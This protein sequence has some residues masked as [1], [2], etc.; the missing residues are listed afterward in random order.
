[1]RVL[2]RGG[3]PPH[4]PVS[5]EASLARW[6][7]GIFGSNVG[8]ALYLE[9]VYRAL[10]TPDTEMTV[11]SLY[12]E[13]SKDPAAMA[14]AINGSFDAYVIPLANAFRRDFL[15]S[16][17]R[18]TAVISLLTI[19][20]VITGV[21]GQSDVG[22][23][24]SDPEVDG[25]VARFVSAVLDRSRSLGVRGEQTA[26]YLRRLGFG[27]DVVDVIGCPSMFDHDGTHRVDRTKERID[28]DS[29]IAFNVAINIDPAAGFDRVIR[30]HVDAYPRLVYVPQEHHELAMLL[31][32]T[33]A[34]TT[35]PDMPLDRT[36][37]FY[38]QDRIRFFLDPT[39][40]KSFM[41]EQDF[42]FGSRIH[43]NVAALAA[44]TPA[45]LL[46]HDARTQELADYHRIP[47]RV[48]EGG[49]ADAA[50]LYD[51]ASFDELNAFMPEAFA[52][53]TDFLDRNALP[54]IHQP[55][56]ANPAYEA[57]LA[58][59][60]FPAAVRS[61]AAETTEF[62]RELLRKLAWLRQGEKNDAARWVGGYMPE[63]KPS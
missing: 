44:G 23:D 8:N 63:W 17:D 22:G 42:A 61:Y 38:R 3:K 45:V 4:I 18:L 31:W 11:D 24:M 26:A 41:K 50:E 13:L 25:A 16:L 15:P 1:M 35:R 54:H 47:Y 43:G 12:V 48:Y 49:V 14:S 52:R 2:I 36:H 51:T 9:S 60:P 57:A 5:P 56:R 10:N 19:P 21:G 20:V 34:S 62:E 53:Y 33:D 46:C 37:P 7:W 39:T 58:T 30:H 59:T 40:W 27:S 6:G 32:G 55:G 29:P 28:Q